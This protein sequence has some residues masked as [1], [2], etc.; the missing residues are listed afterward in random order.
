LAA[1]P[2]A[3]AIIRATHTIAEEALMTSP[4]KVQME[5]YNS[6][7]EDDVRHIVKKYSRIMGWGIPE[8]DEGAARRLILEAMRRAL[9]KVESE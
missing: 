1:K 4:E 3:G 9:A 2:R 7:L 8:L 5:R 6:E